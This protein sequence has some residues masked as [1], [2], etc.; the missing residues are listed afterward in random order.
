MKLFFRTFLVEI[1]LSLL[2][3]ESWKIGRQRRLD[4]RRD[5]VHRGDEIH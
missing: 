1:L 5:D 3:R 2:R 4:E